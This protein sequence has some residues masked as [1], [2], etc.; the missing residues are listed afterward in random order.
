MSSPVR[1]NA[2]TFD[3]LVLA[4]EVPVLVDFWAS[5]CAPC[6]AVDP[7]LERVAETYAKRA[8][9]AKLQVDQNPGIR[10]RYEIQGVPTFVLFVGGEPVAREVG[11]R[12][13][14]DL[15]AMLDAALGGRE[16]GRV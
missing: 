5:S 3:E 12:S 16:A 15:A 13:D 6:K 4:S 9:V 10:S 2:A 14:G 11:A 1:V 7:I 8:R